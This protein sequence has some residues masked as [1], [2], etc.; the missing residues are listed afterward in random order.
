MTEPL[1]TRVQTALSNLQLTTMLQ[2]LDELTQQAAACNWSAL[3]YL[4]QLTQLEVSARFERDV[5]RKMRCR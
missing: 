4:D 3:E 1:Y 2:H 5:Q